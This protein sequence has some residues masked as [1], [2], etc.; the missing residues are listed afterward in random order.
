MVI[1][2]RHYCFTY[3]SAF[4]GLWK[5]SFEILETQHTHQKLLNV[6]RFLPFESSVFVVHVCKKSGQKKLGQHSKTGQA[7]LASYFLDYFSVSIRDH[8]GKLKC[9]PVGDNWKNIFVWTS[10][11]STSSS[12]RYH[13]LR[14]LYERQSGTNAMTAVRLP[15]SLWWQ[16]VL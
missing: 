10:G 12:R 14:R 15:A 9:T 6:D 13:G 3:S 7:L 4:Y 8:K 11:S 1:R 2:V 5:E 16:S